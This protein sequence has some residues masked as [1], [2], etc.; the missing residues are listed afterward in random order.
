MLDVSSRLGF[1]TAPAGEDAAGLVV[2][3]AI[4]GASGPQDP[5]FWGRALFQ[6][7]AHRFTVAVPSAQATS[8]SRRRLIERV[9]DAERPAHTAF[10]LCFVEPRM[11]I[12][13]QSRI[14]VDAIIPGQPAPVPLDEGFTLDVD[15]HLIGE[16]QDA[17]GKIGLRDRV[18]IDTRLG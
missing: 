4:V 9:V 18:G 6:D 16:P 17:P 11:R 5:Q 15:A 2:R 7:N 1:D 12:G 3:E 10:H 14:G 13:V 8:P